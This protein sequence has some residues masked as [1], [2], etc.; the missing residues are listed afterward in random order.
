MEDLGRAGF[1]MLQRKNG[2]RFGEDTVLLSHFAAEY[3]GKRRARYKRVLEFGCNCGAASLLLAARRP[4]VSIVGV[5]LDSLAASVFEKNIALNHLQNRVFSVCTDLRDFNYKNLDEYGFPVI[6]VSKENKDFQKSDVHESRFDMVFFNPPYRVPG[7]EKDMETG[8]Q[9]LR[10]A[11]FEIN[12]GLEDFIKMAQKAL[13][14]KGKLA[15]VHRVSRLPECFSYL[16]KYR[17]CPDVLRFVHPRK[18]KDAKLFL[19]GARMNGKPGGFRTLPPLILYEKLHEPSDEIK[20]IYGD[21]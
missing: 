8:S 19:L 15:M 2:F 18:D 10:N 17:L 11:R 7:R 9:E 16:E 20:E 1:R 6:E 3:L 21:E 5:E 14:P 4:D 12:G 13:L